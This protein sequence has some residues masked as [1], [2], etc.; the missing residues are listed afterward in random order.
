MRFSGCL[1][2]AW[3]V[4]SAVL[5]ATL[6]EN[7]AVRHI[8]QIEAVPWPDQP[9]PDLLLQ[10][11]ELAAALLANP[12]W[13]S[14]APPPWEVPAPQLLAA[15]LEVFLGDILRPAP[16]VKVV[17]GATEG[18]TPGATVTGSTA[19]V[20]WPNAPP[21]GAADLARVLGPPI[22]AAAHVPAAPDPA[23]SEPLLALAEA[24]VTGGRLAL[25]GLP[26]TLRPVSDWLEPDD[27]AAAI[28]GFAAQVLDPTVPWRVREAHLGRTARGGASPHLANAAA[29]VLEA[30]GEVELAQRQPCELLRQW[31]RRRGTPLPPLPAILR[32]AIN[33][34]PR[35]GIPTPGRGRLDPDLEA[36]EISR[37]A[38]QRLLDRG[39]VPPAPLPP[40]TPMWQR[41]LAAANARATGSASVCALLGE[42][43][44]PGLRT[45]CRENDESGGWVY[46]RPS[47]SFEIVAR[48]PSGEEAVLLRWPRWV[49]FPVIGGAG[50]EL[51]FVDEKGVQRVEL[52]GGTRPHLHWEGSFRTLVRRPGAEGLAVVAWPSGEVLVETAGQRQSLHVKGRNGITWL[53]RDVLAAADED[54]LFLVSLA[55]QSRRMPVS[56]ACVRSLAAT[57]GTLLAAQSTPCSPALLRLDLATATGEPMLSL[58]FAPFGLLPLADGSVVLGGGEGL[59]RWRPG[60]SAERIGAGLTP[61]PG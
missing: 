26:P 14:L 7:V 36:A 33:E 49:L 35:A 40:E 12:A 15:K 8:P 34:G 5:S 59:Y 29:M 16:Q 20:S 21:P 25:A 47:S 22:L 56:A 46:V 41:F 61:G 54:G 28:A 11:P 51:F 4:S 39:E 18:A 27:A 2:V 13:L 44:P 55:G 60:G 50:Q 17:V 30:F 24:L 37:A 45:G 57:S 38:L 9:F 32:R 6:A 31:R 10:S 48:A 3:S 53:D 19:V 58:G 1:V 42:S 23:C 52:A 43:L